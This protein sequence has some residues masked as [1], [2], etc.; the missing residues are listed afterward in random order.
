M[1]KKESLRSPLLEVGDSQITQSGLG[2]QSTHAVKPKEMFIAKD[3]LEE[4]VKDKDE[5]IKKLFND[6]QYDIFR[7]AFVNVKRK[8]FTTDISEPE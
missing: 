6:A 5:K 7:E 3:K 4:K 2:K 1:D 8:S